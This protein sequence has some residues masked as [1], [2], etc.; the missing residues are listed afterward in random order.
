LIREILLELKNISKAVHG[1][2]GSK[3]RILDK[4]SLQI[5]K[6]AQAGQIISLLS[7]SSQELT[8]LL[9]ILSAVEKPSEGEVILSGKAYNKPEGKIVFIPS[10]PS[11]FPW[12]NVKQNVEFALNTAENNGSK[13]SEAILLAGLESYEAHF[14][15]DNSLGF[16]F[17]ISLARAIAAGPEIILLDEPL[18]NLHG[19]TKKEIFNLI[20]DIAQKI[21][22]TFII[23][24]INISDSIL[25]SDKIILM[26]RHPGRLADTIDIDKS[27]DVNVHSD[28]YHSVKTEIDKLLLS[29]ENVPLQ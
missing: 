29:Y 17:R 14:P 5:N 8:T 24:S 1:L 10:N 3:V 18:K 12:L 15:D 21:N 16:R 22:V 28:Y 11:S 20:K 2:A 19:E 13:V 27:K 7:A 25:L 9:K 26:K 6:P 4:V 23:A